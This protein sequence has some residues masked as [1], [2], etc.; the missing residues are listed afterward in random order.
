MKLSIIVSIAIFSISLCGCNKRQESPNETLPP[1]LQ[2]KIEAFKQW[3]YAK[4]IIKILRP[5]GPLFWFVDRF[6]DGGEEVLDE[7]C[8]FVCLADC[9]CVGNIV[10]CDGSHLNFPL[11]TIW[12]K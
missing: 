11:E 7:N 2:D 5:D 12:K 3:P 1:C 9:E 4:S 10:Q 8:Q 6:Y